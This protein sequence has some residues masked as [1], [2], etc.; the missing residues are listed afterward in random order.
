MP[1][2]KASTEIKFVFNDYHIPQE[3][4]QFFLY[5]RDVPEFA[6]PNWRIGIAWKYCEVVSLEDDEDGS[7]AKFSENFQTFLTTS[8]FRHVRR[9]KLNLDHYNCLHLLSKILPKMSERLE[10]LE[11]GILFLLT[12][13]PEKEELPIIC[14]P[15]LKRL[16]FYFSLVSNIKTYGWDEIKEQRL[17]LGSM[18]EQRIYVKCGGNES[19]F[20]LYDGTRREFDSNEIELWFRMKEGRIMPQI[21]RVNAYA[22]DCKLGNLGSFLYQAECR[23][24]LGLTDWEV[25]KERGILRILFDGKGTRVVFMQI[26]NMC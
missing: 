22:S 24:R 10:E 23:W 18:A 14:L 1:K 9:L 3:S 13:D 11:I 25:F 4:M 17:I 8:S 6:H 16:V 5:S 7:V 26:K 21:D 15:W 12:F 20:C 2:L 19:H